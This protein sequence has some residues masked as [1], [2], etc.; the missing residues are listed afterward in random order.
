MS[1]MLALVVSLALASAAEDPKPLAEPLV[2]EGHTRAVL[3]V[4]ASPN[5]ELLATG[6]EDAVV[7]VFDARSR[8]LSR[9]L[10]GND[11]DVTALA[12]KRD[13]SM[14]AVGDYYK[15]VRLW[16][17]ATWERKRTIEVPGIVTALAFSSDG[18]VLYVADKDNAVRR[19]ELDAA[20]DA[21]PR[22]FQHSFEVSAMVLSA[23]DATL[24]T[25]DGAGTLTAWD[26]KSGEANWF[27]THGTQ[28]V[29][30]ATLDKGSSIACASLGVPLATYD[31]ESGDRNSRFQAGELEGSALAVGKDEKTLF[32]GLREGPVHVLDALSGKD[33]RTIAT[34]DGIVTALCPLGG[35]DVLVSASRDASVRLT[36]VPTETR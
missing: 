27:R 15:K 28:V 29:A 7:R 32:V 12:F 36:P 16:D 20:E 33:L 31:T 17:T 1:T 21:K 3:C 10:E 9:T 34:H 6:G 11:G 14:L 25:G 24:F 35:G 5:G 2:L 30:L 4:V 22:V 8:A 26:T 23:D 18:K 19:F 13:E